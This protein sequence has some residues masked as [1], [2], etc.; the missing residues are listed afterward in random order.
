MPSLIVLC[1]GMIIGLG[2]YTFHFARASSYLSDQ[3]E[4]C[5]NCHVMEKQYSGWLKGSHRTRAACND[6]HTPHNFA[7]KY[8][9]KAIN[10]FNHSLAFTIGNYPENIIITERNRKITE[11]TCRSCHQD[12][13]VQTP[14]KK[15]TACLQCHAGV[16]HGNR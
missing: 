7:G 15:E 9:T 12:L 1:C 2:L 3:S 13:F 16:G 6:C 8:A 4:A 10:G 14:R 11:D 5:A